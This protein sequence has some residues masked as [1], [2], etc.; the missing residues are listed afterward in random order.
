MRKTIP[1]NTG[2]GNIILDYTGE[3]DD[4][5]SVSSDANDLKQE[6]SQV[7]TFKTSGNEVTRQVTVVQAAKEAV[8]VEDTFSGHP[9]S[10]DSDHAYASISSAANGYSDSDST[11]YATINLTTGSR[12]TTYIYYKFD[13]S[14]I[15]ANATIKSVSC[16]CKCYISNTNSKRI[17]TRQVR[18]YSGA[19]AKGSAETVSNSTDEFEITAGTWSRSELNDA[20]IRLYAVRGTNQT[21]GSQYFRFYGATLTVE[22]EYE[23]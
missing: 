15:P 10:Y 2:S 4:T 8:V 20:R 9:T 7:L 11:N 21:S 1:W 3:G 13:T 14:S 17:E 6:R 23:E 12:A 22:Y 18:L 19:T 5:V 16:T